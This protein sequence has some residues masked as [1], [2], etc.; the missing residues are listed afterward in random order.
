MLSAAIVA[1]RRQ[2]WSAAGRLRF[3]GDRSWGG[4]ACGSDAA[5][6]ALPTLPLG[7]RAAHSHAPQQHV[8]G[9]ERHTFELVQGTALSITCGHPGSSVRIANGAHD[10][11]AV[12]GPGLAVSRTGS[13]IGE[14]AGLEGRRVRS[15]GF[16]GG[17]RQV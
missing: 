6:R 1:G 11:V 13:A 4:G 7:R 10:A 15:T 9:G 8:E 12:A 16:D 14:G 5:C 2:L 17:A 3:G